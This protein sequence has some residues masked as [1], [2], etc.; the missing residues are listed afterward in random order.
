MSGWAT[1][2]G[3]GAPWG[4]PHT[5]AD[6]ACELMNERVLVQ[7]PDAPGERK[8]RDWL[9]CFAEQAGEYMDVVQEVKTAFKLETA[10]GVQ[11]DVIGSLVG[12]PRS[13]ASDTRY[14]LL[15]EIQIELLLSAEP[16]KP[17]W[18][19]TVNNILSIC[20]RFIGTAVVSPVIYQ[21]TPPYGYMLQVP[22]YGTLADLQTLIRFL[23]KATWA[24]V[25][26][27]IIIIV[28]TDDSLWDSTHGAVANSGVW[29][30]AHGVV[31][32]CATWDHV[33]LIGIEPC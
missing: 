15:L 13:G 21:P 26:G 20:R 6:Y 19:G 31:A 28:G 14:R 9:C 11:L 22:N 12:L 33:L 24:G 16:D 30:S 27:Q 29:C 8:F 23:C 18:T 10:V 17:N 2:W 5:G 3:L 32:N 25:L 4:A 1:T 7:H